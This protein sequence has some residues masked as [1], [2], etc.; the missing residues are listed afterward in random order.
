MKHLIKRKLYLIIL[1]FFIVACVTPKLPNL[2]IYETI[3]PEY[4]IDSISNAN[5]FDKVPLEDWKINYYVIDGTKS[6]FNKYI[7]YEDKDSIYSF[8]LFESDTIVSL[9]KYKSEKK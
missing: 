5:N 3:N 9:I 8:T 7:I 1:V 6:V 4:I 2:Y